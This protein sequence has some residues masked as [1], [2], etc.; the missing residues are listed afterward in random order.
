MATWLVHNKSCPIKIL[1]LFHLAVIET[2]SRFIIMQW[3]PHKFHSLVGNYS[4]IM[5]SMVNRHSNQTYSSL[6]RMFRI[7]CDQI[8]HILLLQMAKFYTNNLAIWSYFFRC[9]NRMFQISFVSRVFSSFLFLD[10]FA[11]FLHSLFDRKI[12]AVTGSVTRFGDLLDF[13]KL[14]KDLGKN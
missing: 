13:G 12:F 7:Q 11:L 14:L 8:G 4:K 9:L 10:R 3:R 6:N 1:Y 5:S 2:G